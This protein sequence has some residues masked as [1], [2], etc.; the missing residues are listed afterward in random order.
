MTHSDI[1]PLRLAFGTSVL[2]QQE[3]TGKLDGIGRYTGE[4]LQQLRKF[5]EVEI[6]EFIHGD[7][8]GVDY[9]AAI[10][11]GSFRS[12]ALAAMALQWP[13][14]RSERA[15]GRKFRLVHST[16]H[17]I[18]RLRRIPV[19]ATI[20]DAVP[21]SH[22]QWNRSRYAR[23][24]GALWRRSARWA[25]HIITVSE[26]SKRHI[27][28]CFDVAQERVSVTPLGVAEKW[29]GDTNATDQ[30]RVRAQYALPENYFLFLGVIQPRKNIG[31]LIEAHRLL[32][33]DLR[34]KTPLIAAGP[35]GWDCAEEE[36]ALATGDGGALRHIGQMPEEDLVPLMQGATTLVLPSL[37]EGF[38]LPV[39]E[40]FA[41]GTPVIASN[42][43]AIPEVAGEAALLVD[44]LDVRALAEAM[45][46]VTEDQT[47][48]Q[49]LRGKGSERAQRFTWQ[50]TAELTTSV[51]R[52]V[53]ADSKD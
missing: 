30:A 21:L 4:L 6:G 19:V 2:R 8:A 37:H 7:I 12:Q 3:A 38:G 45:Q 49:S 1:T 20:H 14:P 39:L 36:S 35:Q 41:A 27:A 11:A 9:P 34:R 13:F 22:P 46:R 15:I 25:S 48:A 51:Y 18:P 52:R 24:K 29:F 47:L 53:M 43:G 5:P 28:E 42:A 32:S 16:D 17:F 10:P 23:L 50:R 31:R 33:A 26:T 44:P 40:A